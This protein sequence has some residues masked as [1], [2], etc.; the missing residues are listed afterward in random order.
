MDKRQRD[1]MWKEILLTVISTVVFLAIYWI[2]TMP[3]WK[4]EAL[5]MEIKHRLQSARE[6]GVSLAHRTEIENFR[7]EIS[8]YEHEM[9][10]QNNAG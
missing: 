5:L 4:R 2:Q 10:R 7:R 9:R 8:A 3:D 1:E 6:T